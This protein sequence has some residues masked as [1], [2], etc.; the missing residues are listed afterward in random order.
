MCFDPTNA[1]VFP[2]SPQLSILLCCA[3]IKVSISM[4]ACQCKDLSCLSY[5][6]PFKHVTTNAE[7]LTA[8]YF[9]RPYFVESR[10]QCFLSS[11]SFCCSSDPFR[12]CG[13]NMISPELFCSSVKLHQTPRNI[14][15]SGLPVTACYDNTAYWLLCPSTPRI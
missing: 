13:T 3:D 8:S 1:I 15:V 11:P 10:S 2:L 14:E 9:Q 5:K 7:I 4:K 6:G 12:S